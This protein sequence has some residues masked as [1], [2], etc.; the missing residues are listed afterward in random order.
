MGKL[1]C[2]WFFFVL[3]MTTGKGVPLPMPPRS[4]VSLASALIVG[5]EE[6]GV[7]GVYG[8]GGFVGG[9]TVAGAGGVDV[10][11]DAGFG[12]GHAAV[13]GGLEIDMTVGVKDVLALVAVVVGID[14]GHLG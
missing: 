5:G 6:D 1:V 11:A 14:C 4:S 9:A 10:V 7:V 13:G 3:Q 8:Q 12:M 2:P